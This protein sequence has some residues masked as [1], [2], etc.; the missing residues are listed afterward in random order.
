[1]SE[2]SMMA[3]VPGPFEVRF[4]S[5]GRERALALLATQES[6]PQHSDRH[7]NQRNISHVRVGRYVDDILDG[8]WE[9]THQGIALDEEIVLRRIQHADGRTRGF[10]NDEPVSARLM[11][12]IDAALVEIHGQHDERSLLDPA[13]HL[14]LVD[15]YGD[16]A[17]PLAGVQPRP[18]RWDSCTP[19][20]IDRHRTM[21][22]HQDTWRHRTRG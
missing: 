22:Q 13:A 9:P 18:S 19:T 4:E 12:D 10:L 16:L 8:F 3:V 20:A 1:M 2:E 7:H 17:G 15:A 6:V 14:R 5:I 11:K 21:R